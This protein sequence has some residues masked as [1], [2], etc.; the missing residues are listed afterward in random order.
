MGRRGVRCYPPLW[1]NARG[2]VQC[3]LR[4]KWSF[5]ESLS[6]PYEHG[7]RG[8]SIDPR[9]RCRSTSGDATLR[10]PWQWRWQP[11]GSELTPLSAEHFARFSLQHPM[12]FIG[13]SLMRNEYQ[14]LLCLLGE[15]PHNV[16]YAKS[17]YLVDAAH[18]HQTPPPPNASKPTRS[19]AERVF[20]DRADQLVRLLRALGACSAGGDRVPVPV[21]VLGTGHWYAHEGVVCTS[22]KHQTHDC[23][24]ATTLEQAL[25][26]VRR[27]LER[28]ACN[29]TFVYRSF[30]PRHFAGGDW[31]SGGQCRHGIN[32]SELE[33]PTPPPE[34]TSTLN[35]LSA[36][37][38][39][40]RGNRLR[41][42]SLLDITTMSL[43]RED[44]H[45]GRLATSSAGRYDC[46][47]WCLPGL[48]DVWNHL[49][50][51]TLGID[52]LLHQLPSNG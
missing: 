49:L 46:S 2:T 29:A 22:G 44:A 24:D 26:T 18:L 21:V 6:L 32:V 43:P 5:D 28:A 25:R 12:T 11:Y 47:H 10:Y 41:A 45:P 50:A 23:T 1:K 48:P 40:W 37:H 15:Q 7:K 36:A 13:D 39:A 4:G 8:C 42:F 31:K 52:G 17:S 16:S 30:S 35:A 34:F 14:S 51:A 19:H 38:R 33:V 20:I 3:M 27:A 9:Q